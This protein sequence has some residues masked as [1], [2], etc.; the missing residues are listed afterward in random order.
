MV[1]Y[2]FTA[3]LERDA[4]GKQLRRHITWTPPAGLTPAKMKKA[5]ER[6]ADEWENELRLEFQKEKELGAA[7]TLPPEKRRDN[8]RVFVDDVWFPLQICN[9]ND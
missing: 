8:F 1:S 5:A 3:C 4:N 2:R 9:G 7:Y 6:A